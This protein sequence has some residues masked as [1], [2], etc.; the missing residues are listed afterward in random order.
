MAITKPE[1]HE[2]YGNYANIDLNATLEKFESSLQILKSAGFSQ[3]ELDALEE[4]PKQCNELANFNS[5]RPSTECCNEHLNYLHMDPLE[6]NNS[7]NKMYADNISRIS[8]VSDPTQHSDTDNTIS[9]VRSSS[10]D[11]TKR[12]DDMDYVIHNRS[13]CYTPTVLR[14]TCKNDCINQ[15]KSEIVEQKSNFKAPEP[16]TKS[17][18]SFVARFRDSV[19]IR[20]SSSVPSKSDKNRD[21]SSSNDSGVSTGSLKHHRCDFN[22]F[23]MPITNSKSCKK[24]IKCNMQFRKTMPPSVNFIKSSSTDP[25]KNITF[26][27]DEVA[28]LTKSNSCDVD[29]LTRRIKRNSKS[30]FLYITHQKQL[31]GLK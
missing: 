3:E 10:A 28:T 19:K 14:K 2:D 18:N 5:V 29:T 11:F 1:P 23:E 16:M 20:R 31:N 8:H 26:Q 13:I 17:E 4:N 9:T 7:N 24:H 22:E 15:A 21:S 6:I 12:Q 30:F 25:M 27:F